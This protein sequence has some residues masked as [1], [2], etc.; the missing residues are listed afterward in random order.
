MWWLI[1]SLRRVSCGD[2]PCTHT[3]SAGCCSDESQAAPTPHV[4]W[5]CH[6][7]PGCCVLQLLWQAQP[8]P[9]PPRLHCVAVS[10]YL[11]V[12][13]QQAFDVLLQTRSMGQQHS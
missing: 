6:R 10:A 1:R 4:A 13:L 5:G 7:V 2:P 9:A 11:H 3:H 8:R 12:L